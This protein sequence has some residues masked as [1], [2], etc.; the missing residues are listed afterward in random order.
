M[1]NLSNYSRRR[2]LLTAGASAAASLLLKG[3]LGNPP[4]PQWVRL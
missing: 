3:C 1:T 2:F 4:D